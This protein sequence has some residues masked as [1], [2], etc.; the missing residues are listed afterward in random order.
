MQGSAAC[1]SSPHLQQL[2]LRLGPR[3]FA[4][5]VAK[6]KTVENRFTSIV[7]RILQ[8]THPIFMWVALNDF[9]ALAPSKSTCAFLFPRYGLLV[10]NTFCSNSDPWSASPRSS[11][12]MLGS[13]YAISISIPGMRWRT[14]LLAP[15]TSFKAASSRPLHSLEYFSSTSRSL[16][17]VSLIP[18]TMTASLSGLTR[19][20]RSL[21]WLRS[22]LL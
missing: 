9:K 8:E 10:G 3:Q 15:I 11:A 1:P 4:G 21:K 20:L 7:W 17:R 12:S 13:M 6:T 22:S 2:L 14:V 16:E 18:W 19:F 5:H